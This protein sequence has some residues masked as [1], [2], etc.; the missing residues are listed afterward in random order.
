VDVVDRQ[1]P[2]YQ[3]CWLILDFGRR[4]MKQSADFIEPE[5]LG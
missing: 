5:M 2:V 4:A 3:G 1:Y